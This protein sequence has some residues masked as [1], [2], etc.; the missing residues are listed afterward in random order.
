MIEISGKPLAESIKQQ[1]IADIKKLEN[2]GVKPTISFIITSSDLS[3][4][5]YAMSKKKMAEKLGIE[6]RIIDLGSD[7][8]HEEAMNVIEDLNQDS[9]VHGILVEFPVGKR[10]D[11]NILLEAILPH[12]D[13]DGLNPKNLG[14]LVSG[15]Q[16]EAL[17]PATPQ[18][19]IEL[20]ETYCSLEGKNVAIIGRGKTVGKPLANMLLNRNVTLT[21]CNSKTNNI[22]DSIKN[23]EIIFIA[24]G[25][26]LLIDS[27][28]LSD[29]QIIIDAGIDFVDDKI[30][31]DFNPS[32]KNLLKAYS[33]VPGGVGV[34]TT[35]IIFRN[36]VKAIYLQQKSN[37]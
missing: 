24:I 27:T 7:P 34:V 21:V 3:A 9:S 12:K 13:I 18:A 26:G 32:A 4:R 25:K 5:S 2:D 29:N 22:K 1:I 11:G 17:L 19:C 20:L 10:I 15:K 16:N 23:C 37:L 30:V 35:A 36:L 6:S 8:S 31:G 33:P 14:L 28:H